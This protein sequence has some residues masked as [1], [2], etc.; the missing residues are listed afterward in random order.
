MMIKMTSQCTKAVKHQE[1]ISV[2]PYILQL[3][4]SRPLKTGHWQLRTWIL[5]AKPIDYKSETR[6]REFLSKLKIEHRLL[7]NNMSRCANLCKLI[8]K[9]LVMSIWWVFIV[10]YTS[11]LQSYI[12][13]YILKCL[14][15]FN[16]AEDLE[17]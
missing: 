12:Y 9:T 7:A 3:K 17:N 11:Y 14:V 4:P 6:I 15:D 16:H 8:V 2:R 5:K 13:L 10:E 1:D